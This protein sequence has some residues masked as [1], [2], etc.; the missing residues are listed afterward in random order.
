MWLKRLIYSF[1]LIKEVLNVGGGGCKLGCVVEHNRVGPLPL[2]A[3]GGG[4]GTRTRCSLRIVAVILLLL[5]GEGSHVKLLED[6]AAAAPLQGEGVTFGCVESAGDA[7]GQLVVADDSLV[8]RL[9]LVGPGV[10]RDGV[11]EMEGDV[12]DG[13]VVFTEEH[14]GVHLHLHAGEDVGVVTAGLHTPGEGRP[15]REQV[16]GSQAGG[17]TQMC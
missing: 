6:V 10:G 15:D 9:R 16:L 14:L 1:Y 5:R 12:V 17:C 11:G 13:D 4:V 8:P 7:A 3:G 2:P